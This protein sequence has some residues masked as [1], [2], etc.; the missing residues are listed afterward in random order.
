M[1]GIDPAEVERLKA[2]GFPD[3][4]RPSPESRVFTDDPT[5]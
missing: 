3:P 5:E 1:R 4:H 2:L